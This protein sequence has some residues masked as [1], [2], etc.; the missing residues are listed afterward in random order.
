MRRRFGVPVPATIVG[1]VA[2]CWLPGGALL[3][4]AAVAEEL[5]YDAQVAWFRAGTVEMTL[6]RTGDDYEL[7]GLVTTAGPMSRILK[8]RGEFAATGR[9]V[10]GFPVTKAYLLLE[11]DGESREVLLAF[12]GKTTIHATDD[13]SEELLAPPG[14]DL[15]SV[16]FLAP[17]CFGE[18]DETIVHDGEDAYRIVPERTSRARLRQRSHYYS[19]PALRCDYRFRYVDGST[20]RVSVWLAD[21]ADRQ[22]PVR[23]QVRVPLLPDGI[24]R[25]RIDPTVP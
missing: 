20:R 21:A 14:S 10:D 8:W 23:I 13:E 24:L 1:M 9:F 7:S 11:D 3:A 5:R 22:F 19:G 18:L 17:H 2:S 4:G 15:M 16:M 25:L 12:G 6:R